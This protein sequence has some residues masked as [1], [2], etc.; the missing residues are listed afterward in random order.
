MST[1]DDR[2]LSSWGKR[3]ASPRAEQFLEGPRSRAQELIR[4]AGIATEFIRGFRT[5]HFLGPCVTV[6]GSARFTEAH[7]F[8]QEAQQLASRLAIDDLTVMTGGGPGIMEAANRGARE[9]GGLSVGCNI[10]LPKEQEPNPYLDYW[11][12]FEH[13]FVR[14]V[15][16][17]KYSCA[18]VAFPGGYGTLDE[19]FETAT[20]IQTKK[21]MNFP[22]ILFG[23]DYWSPLKSFIEDT[24][25]AKGTISS[26]DTSI[27][28]ITDSVDDVASM[29][30]EWARPA[31]EQYARRKAKRRWWLLEH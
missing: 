31:M 26:E 11:V 23:S 25:L 19:V 20:L 8:Y 27:L 14:K 22:L 3:S 13:F 1:F 4:V 29:I 2:P 30:Q 15:M 16:L 7:P 28:Y 9:A 5:F 18:F 21:I 10:K 6:F 12:E 17:L 24:L